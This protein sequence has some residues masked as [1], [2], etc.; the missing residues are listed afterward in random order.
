MSEPLFTEGFLWRPTSMCMQRELA[1]SVAQLN[2]TVNA[3][4]VVSGVL[5][6]FQFVYH[7]GAH[8]PF[9]HGNYDCR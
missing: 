7:C 3:A 4:H 1:G 6:H 2:R 8:P 9:G 5:A